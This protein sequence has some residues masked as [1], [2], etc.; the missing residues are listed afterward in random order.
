MKLLLL[1]LSDSSFIPTGLHRKSKGAGGVKNGGCIRHG[2][3]PDFRTFFVTS[4]NLQ[5]KPFVCLKILYFMYMEKNVQKSQLS[6]KSCKKSARSNVLY[7]KRHLSTS[8]KILNQNYT[9][10]VFVRT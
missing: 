7:H 5:K 6:S 9:S 8:Y 4:T 1:A 10:F 2:Y 3:T